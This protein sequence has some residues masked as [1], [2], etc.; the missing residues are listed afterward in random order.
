VHNE[1]ASR[2]LKRNRDEYLPR[3]PKE[4]ETI[5][6]SSY[7][8][9]AHELLSKG[10]QEFLDFKD[11]DLGTYLNHLVNQRTEPFVDEFGQVIRLY[12]KVFRFIWEQHNE[13]LENNYAIGH[14]DKDKLNLCSVARFL[15]HQP[16][17]EQRVTIVQKM[18]DALRYRCHPCTP[19]TPK[20]YD[21]TIIPSTDGLSPEGFSPEESL[22]LCKGNQSNLESILPSSDILQIPS[23]NIQYLMR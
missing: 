19:Y 23:K 11:A 18:G 21:E 2:S 12:K 1:R 16:A 17:V 4:K 14:F 22:M 9:E 3:V 20:Q 6:L 10:L 7:I 5:L 13:T 8:V 15:S